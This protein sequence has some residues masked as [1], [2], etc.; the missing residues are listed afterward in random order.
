[1]HVELVDLFR[2]TR[3]H[4]DTWLIAAA[5]VTRDRTIIEGVLGC[6]ICGAEY[7]VR[8]GVVSFMEV[9]DERN[10]AAATDSSRGHESLADPIAATPDRE[11]ENSRD[12]DALRLAAFL[13]LDAPGKT[14]A[15]IG[16]PMQY[17]ANLFDVVATRIVLVNS[18][19]ETDDTHG[20]P[21]ARIVCGARLPIAR[22]SLNGI[23]STTNTL[24][25]NVA[26]VLRSNGRLLSPVTAALP[27]GVTELARDE[28]QWVATRDVVASPPITLRRQSSV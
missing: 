18:P 12:D 8:D 10:A 11:P 26:E 22:D 1:M 3:R 20:M 13:D 15:L 6:P 2:C 4:E 9:P 17:A 5:D 23:A 19:G 27:S 25:A 7:P 28:Q 14:I 16:Y 21:I 24:P